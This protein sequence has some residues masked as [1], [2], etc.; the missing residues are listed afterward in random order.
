MESH[1]LAALLATCAPQVDTLTA[2]AL[3]Q[4]ESA[5]NPHAVGV[6]GGT[7]ARQ[8][9]SEAEALA[10]LRRLAAGGWDY[11]VGLAQI[12][13]RNFARLGLTDASALD[14]CANLRAMQAVLSECFERYR[15]DTAAQLA[16]RRAL[17]CYYSGNAATGFRHGYVQR[18]LDAAQL[19]GVA[20]AR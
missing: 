7:L 15:R 14:P 18:V 11:S 17:S 12:N 6:V 10:T 9:R 13:R 4:V 3:V 1:L 19:Q 2:R 8:P 16:L 5:F 20:A